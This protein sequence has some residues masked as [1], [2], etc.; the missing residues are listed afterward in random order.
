MKYQKVVNNVKT[1]QNPYVG[2]C[3]GIRRSPV[4]HKVQ[5]CGTCKRLAFEFKK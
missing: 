2:L 4:T 3:F 5:L 1:S